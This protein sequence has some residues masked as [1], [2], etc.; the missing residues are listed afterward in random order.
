ML[1][2]FKVLHILFCS[3]HQYVRCVTRMSPQARSTSKHAQQ[4]LTLV[5]TYSPN[6]NVHIDLVAAIYVLVFVYNHLTCV[7]CVK[8]TLKFR[9]SFK[10]RGR[11]A[12]YNVS[13]NFKF[14]LILWHVYIAL[15][16]VSVL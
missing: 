4:I 7:M 5:H 9:L 13:L 15:V 8:A 2:T 3:S 11:N 10:A 16:R 14:R 6:G 12:L 1:F